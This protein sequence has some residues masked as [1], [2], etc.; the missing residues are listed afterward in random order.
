MTT[1]RGGIILPE[2]APLDRWASEAIGKVQDKV[3]A[4]Y[5]KLREAYPNARILVIGYPYLFPDRDAPYLNLSDCQTILRRF[6]HNERVA[7]RGL[8]DELNQR[9]HDSAAEA[10]VE[11]ISP[12]AGWKDH[13]PC[14]KSEQQYT[15]SIKPFILSSGAGLT[16]GDGGTFHPNTA[17]QRELAQLVTCYLVAH[18]E[19]LGL[20]A[21]QEPPGSAANPIPDCA[22]A[23]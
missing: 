20:I 8:Q 2:P 16:P 6:S 21:G 12:A 19:P 13:E 11:F 1:L 15:N 9:L 17:G 18:P 14:G 22:K 10:R 5:P 4:L 7:V 3:D 23:G